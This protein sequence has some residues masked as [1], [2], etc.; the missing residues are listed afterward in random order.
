MLLLLMDPAQRWVIPRR[1]L[2][3]LLLKLVDEEPDT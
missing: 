3:V 1:L 2:C